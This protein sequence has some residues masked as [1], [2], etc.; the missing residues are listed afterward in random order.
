MLQSNDYE[1]YNENYD[2]SDNGINLITLLIDARTVYE[3]IQY[4][5]QG[6]HSIHKQDNI[7]TVVLYAHLVL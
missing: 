7:L 2:L 5:Y 4:K 3:H 6:Q 1:S